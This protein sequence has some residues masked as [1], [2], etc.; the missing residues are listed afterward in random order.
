MSELSEMLDDRLKSIQHFL[1]IEL[2]HVHPVVSRI[3]IVWLRSLI[4]RFEREFSVISEISDFRQK[5]STFSKNRN[6]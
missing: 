1:G 3:I 4:Y 6:R 5:Y 2:S